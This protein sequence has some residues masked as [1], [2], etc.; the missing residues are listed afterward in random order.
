METNKK[1]NTTLEEVVKRNIKSVV[2]R[3]ECKEIN[4]NNFIN[5]FFSNFDV[6]LKGKEA[7]KMKIRCKL[8]EILEMNTRDS[9][10]SFHSK[11]LN[12]PE[13]INDIFKFFD[14][15]PKQNEV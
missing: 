7:T 6:S 15:K 1:N 9:I 2:G 3:P 5:D 10:G 4:E 11:E 8:Q 14:L 13:L 12:E